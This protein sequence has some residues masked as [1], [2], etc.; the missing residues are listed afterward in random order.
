MAR[1]QRWPWIQFDRRL[2]YSNMMQT[3]Q[4]KESQIESINSNNDNW[5][6]KSWKHV[7]KNTLKKHLDSAS[8]KK[9]ADCKKRKNLGI[10]KHTEKVIDETPIGKGLKRMGT[11]GKKV[12]VIK[13]N[14]AYCLAKNERPF[15]D[16]PGPVELQEKS[17]V[18]DIGKVYLTDK[19]CAGFTKHIT[20]AIRTELDNDLKNCN[21]FTC[22][23]DRS[24]GSSITEQEVICVLY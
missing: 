22:L 20:H 11:D 1:I 16:Y 17:E 2:C 18:M 9:A 12:L 3:L 14:T 19:K 8:H 6:Q 21:Y 7:E 24:T 4:E 23:K 13:L 15:S 5:V 10:E